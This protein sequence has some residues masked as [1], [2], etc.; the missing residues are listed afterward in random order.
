M[1][2]AI[3]QVLVLTLLLSA[4]STAQKNTVPGQFKNS[5]ILET[6]D[7]EYI[8]VS[9]K[10]MK[11]SEAYRYG[12]VYVTTVQVNVNE[13]GEN[14]L[15]D[16]ANEPS[17]AFDPTD[18][19][20]MVI[21]WRQ[22][23]TI[24]SNFRQ[25]GYGYTSDGGLTWTFPG[26]IEPGVFRSDPVLD[27]DKWG[28]FYFNSLSLDSSGL[29][30]KVFLSGNQGTEWDEGTFAQGGDKPW[31]S[32]DK[33]DG[34]GSGNIYNY[35]NA[36]TI[37]PPHNFTRSTNGNLSY[38]DCSSIL[39]DPGW[40]TTAIN[41]QGKL[42][43]AGS[44][45]TNFVVARSSNAQYPGQVVTWDLAVPVYL[46]GSMKVFAGY[47]SPNPLGLLGQAVIAIDSSGT[48]TDG[49]IYLMCSVDRHSNSDP[50]DVMFSRSTDEGETWSDPVQVNDDPGYNAWQWFGTM[51][52]APNGRIDAIWL[53][54]RGH[55]GTVISELY[56]SYSLNGGV[57]WSINESI[58][59]S[60]D[61]HVGWPD[62]NKMG[63]YFH[64]FSDSD[65]AH[66]AWAAT[67][68]GE[69]D[70]YYSH[71]SQVT[72]IKDDKGTTKRCLAQN[73]PNPFV[74][75]TS[76]RYTVW[77]RSMTTIE[78]TDIKGKVIRTLVHRIHSPGSYQI[79][80]QSRG[81]KQG[82]YYY[83]LRSGQLIETRKLIVIK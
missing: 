5:R 65:C 68:N 72:G 58:S 13:E 79:E 71:I 63:D 83:T 17:I 46:D 3:I 9:R 67:F 82:M 59:E 15:G 37:C 20:N 11:T 32:I 12:S 81:L 29:M 16:A 8:P 53:D 30:S 41:A 51:S 38:E 70:I 7:D 35:W 57:T 64:M 18:H 60:F 26:T 31:M 21:G 23:D 76:I 48:E 14:M 36:S 66:L 80:L 25:A 22:F 44:Q 33:T 45:D 55:P 56:Y 27:S 34:P 28:N 43:V 10:S 49:N 40:G 42:F 77:S 74:D 47:E 78:L 61:P 52:V 75:K 54:T 1:N 2:K 24:A 62:Q 50:G 19:N 4:T 69:Q 39:G 73:F 6:V